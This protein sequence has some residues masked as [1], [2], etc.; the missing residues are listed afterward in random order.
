[1]STHLS[2]SVPAFTPHRYAKTDGQ[3]WAAAV[4]GSGGSS[5][6]CAA[7]AGR[8]CKFGAVLAE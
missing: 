5:A 8:Y 6:V 1:M 4:V 7:E 2:A 3:F